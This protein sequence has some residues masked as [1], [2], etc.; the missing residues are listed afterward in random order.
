[1]SQIMVLLVLT[2]DGARFS[3]LILLDR[4]EEH[5]PRLLAT[6]TVGIDCCLRA[7]SSITR[8]SKLKSSVTM[9]AD[10]SVRVWLQSRS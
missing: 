9:E 4:S 2:D 8:R 10:S 3:G 5:C 6:K 7:T 1:M